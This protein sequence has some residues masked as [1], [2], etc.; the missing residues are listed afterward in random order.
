[1]HT[2]KVATQ[3]RAICSLGLRHLQAYSPVLQSVL[4]EAKMSEAH[5]SVTLMNLEPQTGRQ[6]ALIHTTNGLSARDLDVSVST[7][8]KID[9][10]YLQTPPWFIQTVFLLSAKPIKTTCAQCT[11]LSYGRAREKWLLPTRNCQSERR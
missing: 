6:V 8:S 10:S 2:R 7:R 11:T 1:M 3:V 9:C 5:S 4:D